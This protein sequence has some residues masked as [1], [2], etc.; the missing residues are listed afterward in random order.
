MCTNAP[1]LFENT[2]FEAM[3]LPGADVRLATHWL[4]PAAADGLFA[5]LREQIEWQQH[6][7]HIFGREL[8]APRLSCWIGDPGLHYRY[9]G[10][11]FVPHPWPSA[12]LPLRARLAD[13]CGAAFN[14]V[15]ANLYRDGSDSMGWHADDERELG[16]DPV[17]ASVSLGATRRFVLRCR[18]PGAR[19]VSMELPHG[20]L[21]RMAGSTQQNYRHALP[22]TRKVVGPRIN[23][24][25]RR[26]RRAE[27]AS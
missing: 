8:D 2:R 10:T 5:A 13:V 19:S 26:I 15:L 14:S 11:R 16:P 6:R 9:S 23:L 7:L 3:H 20:S 4:D 25:F 22:R 24:T 18:Q 21:L 12:L 17:I 1:G 27:R